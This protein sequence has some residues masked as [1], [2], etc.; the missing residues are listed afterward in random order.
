MNANASAAIVSNPI[1]VF[2]KGR[3]KNLM[4]NLPEQMTIVTILGIPAILGP[5]K[6][7]EGD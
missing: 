4:G 5:T 2:L 1:L 6:I 3:E 7:S